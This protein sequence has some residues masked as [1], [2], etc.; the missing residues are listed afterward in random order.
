MK[1]LGRHVISTSRSGTYQFAVVEEM[2]GGK[3]TVKLGYTGKGS[4][5]TNLHVAGKIYVGGLVIIDYS[6]DRPYVRQAFL[7]EEVPVELRLAPA[8]YSPI[9]EDPIEA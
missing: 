4:R 2:S 6:V 1:L 5:I 8:Y 3:A 9:E 7:D